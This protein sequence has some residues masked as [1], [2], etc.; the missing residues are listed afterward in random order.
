[1][2]CGFRWL[3]LFGTGES[4]DLGFFSVVH[5]RAL[6]S[7]KRGFHWG[8]GTA[9]GLELGVFVRLVRYYS[10]IVLGC[11][12]MAEFDNKIQVIG[13]DQTSTYENSMDNKER[14][15]QF[16]TTWS[17][18]TSSDPWTAG[19]MSDVFVVP[20][21]N[22]M[23][24]EVY[25]IEWDSEACAVKTEENDDTST[26]PLPTT[27]TFNIEDPKNQPALAFFSRY[28]VNYVKI[29][30]LEAAIQ[31]IHQSLSIIGLLEIMSRCTVNSTPYIMWSRTFLSTT[32]R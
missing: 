3:L 7:G 17:Y 16:S 30:E 31:M 26:P 6:D 15:I 19:A 5:V 32:M 2:F 21:L 13:F 22:V 18:E 28:H 14:S 11:S 23:Y 1:M 25:I 10:G 4:T 24:E 8:Q 12:N 20:N 29:P 9:Q 27:T